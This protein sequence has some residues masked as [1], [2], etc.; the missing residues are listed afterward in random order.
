MMIRG[1]HDK[2]GT[3]SPEV[4]DESDTGNVTEIHQSVR[5]RNTVLDREEKVK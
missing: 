5:N 4:M 3:P 1:L 2:D